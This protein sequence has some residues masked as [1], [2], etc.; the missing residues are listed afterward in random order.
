[1]SEER[2]RREMA[3]VRVAVILQAQTR[4]ACGWQRRKEFKGVAEASGSIYSCLKRL[5]GY[6]FHILANLHGV[7]EY[8]SWAGLWDL[9]CALSLHSWEA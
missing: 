3:R 9:K 2:R 5:Q 7:L 6:S 4:N 8:R 1:M